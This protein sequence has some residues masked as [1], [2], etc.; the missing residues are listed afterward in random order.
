[1]RLRTL[2]AAV[3]L[4][5]S[6]GTAA[7]DWP[8]RPIRLVHGFAPGGNADIISRLLAA[9]L[10]ESLGKPVIVDPKP[11]SA[12]NIASDHVA[13]QPADGYTLVLFT[14]GHAV[15]AALYDKLTFDAVGDFQ[16]ISTLTDFAF[17]IAARQDF[18]ARDFPALLQL[19]RRSTNAL[20]YGTAGIG[21]TQHLTGELLAS[22][23]EVKLQHIPYKGGSA[24]VTAVLGGE[25]PLI[26]ESASVIAPQVKAGSFKALA[27]TQDTRWPGMPEVPTIA[28]S[29]VPGFNVRSWAGIA[30]PKGTPRPIVERLNAEIQRALTLELV[31]TRL[32]ELGGAARGS[33]P[34]AMRDMVAGEV[35]R[36]T[37]V[38][39]AAKIPKQ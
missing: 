3:A 33:T 37:R 5:L 8:E 1:M 12:G 22:T 26:I 28:E 34:E 27:V 13:K 17:M 38:I 18:V 7:A 14:G 30:A 39:A 25:V 6:A 29:G 11:G 15:S 10:S 2:A 35:A 32:A 31:S 19:A 20:Q 16:M 9:P 23:A 21:S 36:W 4:A 24:V